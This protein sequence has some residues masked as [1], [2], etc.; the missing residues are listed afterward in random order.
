[1]TMMKAIRLHEFGGPQVLTYEDAPKPEPKEGEVLIKVAAAGV[2]PVDAMIESGA[3]EEMAKHTLPLVPGWDAAGTVEML[4]P[5]VTGFTVGDAIFAFADIRRDGTYAEYAVIAAE[6]LCSKPASLDFPAAASIP[7]AGTTAWQAL[8]E[9]ANLQSGQ[10]I[11][12]H[13]AG[14]AVG[15]F[16]VQFAKVKGATVIATAT[17]DDIAYVRSIGANVV[18]DYKTEKFEDA[19]HGVD[20]V[21]DTISGETQA[22]SWATL[23]D[24]GVLVS[25]LP[26]A[27]APPE[28]AARGVQGKSFM[29]HPD[30]PQLKEIAGL[31][32]A[33]K[34]ETRIGQTF[35]LSEAKQ[36]QET[37]KSGHT[38]GKIVLTV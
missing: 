35:P 26:G 11:L 9:E 16:A 21:L 5:G 20:A 4:G 33:G 32:D 28:A 12:I 36:A 13:G 31:V 23:R 7:L 17:G 8:F 3:M 2:N 10:T 24:G 6:A 14:G 37:A 18:V 38:K 30:G 15:A 19:A 29:A 27:E 34:V 25:T 22:R 1:M